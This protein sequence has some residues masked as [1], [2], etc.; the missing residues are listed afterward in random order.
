[1]LE[2]L[3]GFFSRLNNLDELIRWGGYVVL[4][5]IIFSETGLFF[6]FFLPGDSLLVTAGLFA[7]KGDLNA[8]TLFVLGSLCA[9]LGDALGFE[10]GK[11]SGRH[12]SARPDSF[13]FK[14]KHLEKTQEFYEKHGGKAII[15]ARF[16]PI[17]RTFAPLVAGAAG[18]RYS[19][20]VFFNIVGGITWVGSMV[21][22][23]YVLGRSIPHIDRYIDIVI[24]A[25]IFFS[26]FPGIVGY[27]RTGHWRKWLAR[28]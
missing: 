9:I 22:I 14:K 10:I 1:M 19:A 7:A 12:I 27:L 8:V 26:L 13:F 11:A 4:M 18:M 25:V 15:I 24:A 5:A 28:A 20:F 17:V 3:M 16:M 21:G 6:G 23:G 2:T